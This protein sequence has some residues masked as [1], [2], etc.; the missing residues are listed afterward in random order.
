MHTLMYM[1]RPPAEG[2]FCNK[3]EKA[4]KPVTVKGYSQYM[5]YV[6]KGDRMTYSYSHSWRTWKWRK[7]LFFHL[8]D[9]TVLNS[10]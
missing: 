1:H 9:L 4:Q 6:D 3:H 10:S 8:L 5:R 2:H 7:Q